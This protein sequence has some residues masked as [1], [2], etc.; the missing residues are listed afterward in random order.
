MYYKMIV[1]KQKYVNIETARGTKARVYFQKI[2]TK[3]NIHKT[4]L[5]KEQLQLYDRYKKQYDGWQL[6]IDTML[7]TQD[8]TQTLIYKNNAK[9]RGLISC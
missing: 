6:T 7:E 8:E 5:T 4:M 1:Y 3:H 2:A 9:I